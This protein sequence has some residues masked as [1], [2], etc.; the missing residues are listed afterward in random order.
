VTWLRIELERRYADPAYRPGWTSDRAPWASSDNVRR[1]FGAWAFEQ[2]DELQRRVRAD[3]IK[4]LEAE[5]TPELLQAAAR[6]LKGAI[7]R[8]LAKAEGVRLVEP[9]ADFNRICELEELRERQGGKGGPGRPA[10][11][12]DPNTPTAQAARDLWRLRQVILPRFWPEAGKGGVGP[13]NEALAAI[14]AARHAG[15]TA[16]E[17]LNWYKNERLASL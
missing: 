2:L 6:G 3:R 11:G 15:V 14:V 4:E 10:S 17:A 9:N 13:T 16:R 12:A 8:M 1:E 5:I 7:P